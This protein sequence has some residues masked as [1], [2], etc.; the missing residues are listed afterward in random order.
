MTENASTKQEPSTVRRTSQA[1]RSGLDVMLSEAAAGSPPRFF[2]PG[3][4][5]RVAAGL[6]RHPNRV[7]GRAAGLSAELRRVAAGRSEIA[8]AKGD[9]RFHD[10]AWAGSWLFRRLLQG[11]LAIGEAVDGLISDADVDWRAERQARLVAGN[12]LDALAPTNF[13]WSN[14]EVIKE[15]VNTGGE[16]LVQVR[17]RRQSRDLARLSRAAHGRVRA[18]PLQAHDRARP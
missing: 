17:S 18:D 12:V 8:P 4:A 3:P 15:T 2:A 7:A 10:P 16:N 13:P 5:V 9:R 6:A 11:Y 14:P 1:A